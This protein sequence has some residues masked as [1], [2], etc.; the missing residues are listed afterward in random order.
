LF[1][2]LL[3]QTSTAHPLT[4]RKGGGGG[5]GGGG[6]GFS[7]SAGSMSWKVVLVIVGSIL[8]ML[9]LLYIIFWQ[10]IPGGRF[11]D[12]VKKVRDERLARKW[13]RYE[14]KDANANAN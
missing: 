7:F 14:A 3:I 11:Y 8:G 2:T 1:F 4:K 6:S 12:C 9:L 10:C 13:A 5:R